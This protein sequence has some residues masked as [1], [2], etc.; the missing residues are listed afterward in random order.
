MKTIPI[1]KTIPNASAYPHVE[2]HKWKET[3]G[4]IDGVPNNID[5]EERVLHPGL[6]KLEAFTM[7]AMQG[8]CEA[9]YARQLA[10]EVTKPGLSFRETIGYA[11]VQV[12]KATIEALNKEVDNGAIS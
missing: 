12:A 5:R 4:Y 11:A 9:A 2:L 10:D 1:A 6:T 8:M 7:A 3:V